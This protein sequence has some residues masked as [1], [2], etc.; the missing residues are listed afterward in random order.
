MKKHAAKQ[1]KPPRRKRRARPKGAD[2]RDVDT[3]SATVLDRRV[4]A[5][6][7]ELEDM[8]ADILAVEPDKIDDMPSA[9]TLSE[10]DLALNQTRLDA[11]GGNAEAR[12]TLK[13]IHAM[14]DEAAA[15]RDS[16]S[17]ADG[18]RAVLRRRSNRNRR[19]RARGHGAGAG[20]GGPPASAEEAHR[21]FLKPLLSASRSEPFE[22]NE[23]IGVAISIFPLHYAS[24]LVERPRKS[25][26]Q[27]GALRERDRPRQPSGRCR[28][29]RRRC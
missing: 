26:F 20:F 22:L 16:S 23:E 17:H 15:R 11:A 5:D 25:W 9:G 13:N 29:R 1:R 12:L 10:P 21:A 2:F 3:A 27:G 7:D 24:A 19:C 28:N 8:I 4:A 14:I 6:E 18:A